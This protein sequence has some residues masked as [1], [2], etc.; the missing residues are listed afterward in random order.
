MSSDLVMRTVE[1]QLD[2]FVFRAKGQLL[3]LHSTTQHRVVAVREVDSFLHN[4][5]HHY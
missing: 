5:H 1:S 2:F 3:P 4:P